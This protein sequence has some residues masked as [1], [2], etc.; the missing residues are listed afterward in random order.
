MSTTQ[1]HLGGKSQ[2]SIFARDNIIISSGFSKVPSCEY[3]VWDTRNMAEAVA[4]E[5]LSKGQSVINWLMNRQHDIMYTFGKGQM[6]I[7]IWRF[8]ES[9]PTFL[10]P[11]GETMS[12]QPV[13]GFSLMPPSCNDVRKHEI[14]RGLKVLNNKTMNIIGFSLKNRIDSFQPELYPAHP[15]DQPA[16]TPE[17][18]VAGTDVDPNLTEFTEEDWHACEASGG[19]KKVKI[20][21]SAELKKENEEM[22]VQLKAAN[23]KI[24]ALEA[25]L[26][27]LKA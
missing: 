20:V 16:N 3:A 24:A 17:N 1:S 14:N 19:I 21:S 10:K 25:E 2:K 7:G 6:G 12:T 15:S 9:H 26:A 8:D 4:R 13:I 27:A 22:K 5:S 23:D 18:W 11:Y